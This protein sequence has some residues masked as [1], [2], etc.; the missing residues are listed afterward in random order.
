MSP[1]NWNRG[2][3]M[4]LKTMGNQWTTVVNGNPIQFWGIFNTADEYQDNNESGIAQF[5]TVT[6]LNVLTTDADQFVMNQELR[7][8][9]SEKVWCVARKIRI[10]DGLLTMLQLVEKSQ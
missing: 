8:V 7:E 1:V 2:L 6:T 5:M 10:D 4:M 9:C 3:S